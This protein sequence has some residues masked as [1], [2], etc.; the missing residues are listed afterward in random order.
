MLATAK[1]PHWAITSLAIVAALGV[2]LL[3]VRV[4]RRTARHTPAARRARRRPAGA[5][6]GARGARRD[7]RPAAA[8]LAIF[9]QCLGWICQLLA[10]YTAMRAFDIH[11][12]LPA[13]A[14]VLVLMNIATIFPLWPGN[15]GLAAGGGRDAARPYGVAVRERL[16]VRVGLQA[17]EMSVGVGVGLVFLAR[18]GI[19]FAM[20]RRMPEATTPR[21][22][23]R[24][25]RAERDSEERAVRALACPASL[26]GVLTAHEAAAALGEGLRA[27]GVGG[28]RA[29]GRRRRRGDDATS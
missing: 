4:R 26:K 25:G 28:R 1:I 29:A 14:L 17:I 27:A 6:D 10:V 7:A 19:S 5:R 3:R 20:L 12:P 16:R 21:P 13:A 8:R 15:V 24:G 11:E 2:V 22:R 9:F 23:R 18:E